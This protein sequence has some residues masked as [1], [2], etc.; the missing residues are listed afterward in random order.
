[1]C[2][3]GMSTM[4]NEIDLCADLWLRTLR[5]RAIRCKVTG[6]HTLCNIFL[7]ARGVLICALLLIQCFV[8]LQKVNKLASDY[9]RASI[10]RNFGKHFSSKRPFMSTLQKSTFFISLHRHPEIW[11]RPKVKSPL[12]VE[13]HLMTPKKTHY[14]FLAVE[15]FIFYGK[16]LTNQHSN[17]DK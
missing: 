7:K 14:C 5:P 13:K 10:R 16:M 15:K 3:W 2:E 6:H 9:K 8:R 11:K 4:K 1:M 17:A 12:C